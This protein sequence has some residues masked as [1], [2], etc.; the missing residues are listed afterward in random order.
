M[1]NP[2]ISLNKKDFIIQTF[3]GSGPGGQHRNKRDTGVRL[4]HPES[5]ARGESCEHRSQLQNKHSAL[6]K[7]VLDYRFKL[8]YT[9]LLNTLKH[10]QPIE[11]LVSEQLTEKNLKFEIKNEGKWQ[12]IKETDI[13]LE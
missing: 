5:G 10:K 1:P 11:E 7:L 3:R 9:K 2:L 6:N 13:P 12:Q 8:W 4:I